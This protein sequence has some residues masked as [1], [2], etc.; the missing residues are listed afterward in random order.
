MSRRFRDLHTPTSDT[1]GQPGA[2]AL[3]VDIDAL[4]DQDPGDELLFPEYQRGKSLT[5]AL[6]TAES[7]TPIINTQ[8]QL[9]GLVRDHEVSEPIPKDLVDDDDDPFSY[10]DELEEST[11]ESRDALAVLGTASNPISVSSSPLSAAPE[12]GADEGGEDGAIVHD[13]H[14]K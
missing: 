2:G 1:S 8:P 5:P 13:D 3:L 10:L 14:V 4:Y 9:L 12:L 11:Q 6:I 7:R